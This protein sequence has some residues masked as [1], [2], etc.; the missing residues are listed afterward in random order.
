MVDAVGSTSPSLTAQIVRQ[1]TQADQQTVSSIAAQ[2]QGSGQGT[3]SARTSTPPPV[4]ESPNHN[5]GLK[6]ERPDDPNAPRGSFL[7][8]SV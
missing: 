3:S 7:D 1:V 8:I 6:G 4:Q 5:A 2:S